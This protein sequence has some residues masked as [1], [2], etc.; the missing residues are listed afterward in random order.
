MATDLQRLVDGLVRRLQRTVAIDDREVRLVAYSSHEGVRVDP[1]RQYSILN[2]RVPAE[3]VRYVQQVALG[4]PGPVRL[5]PKPALGLEVARI[6]IPI[7]DAGATLGWLILL[8]DEGPLDEVDLEAAVEA[9]ATATSLFL[10]DRQAEEFEQARVRELLPGLLGGE[11]LERKQAAESL[12]EAGLFPSGEPLAAIVVTLGPGAAPIHESERDLLFA[13]FERATRGLSGRHPLQLVRAD[14]AVL[15]VA[16]RDVGRIGGLEAVARS[17]VDGVGAETACVGIGEAVDGLEGAGRSYRQARQ[18]ANMAR[19]VDR[20]RVASYD[21][22]GVYA[23]L[24]RIPAG[25]LTPE[26]LPAPARRL[27]GSEGS[28]RVLAETLECYLDHAGN[29][30]ATA[31]ALNVHRA[32]LYY[33]LGR[34]EA[35]AGV[36]LSRG[37]DRLSLHLGLKLARMLGLLGGEAGPPRQA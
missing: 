2:R 36:D 11:E 16:T 24:A 13:A 3:V 1:L 29:V 9:A 17:L 22:L 6:C 5:P 8:D 10:R 25:E 15:L 21:Q 7:A 30:R 31:E 37:D 18:A 14:H 27:L 32:T 4:S 12:V 33:R 34:V 19:V 23:L 28:G 20:S 26:T 35:V